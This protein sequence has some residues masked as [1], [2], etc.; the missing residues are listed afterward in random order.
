MSKVIDITD[1]LSFEENPKILIKN[2]EVSVNSDATT[3][4]QI[5]Q[6]VGEGKNI[7]P[8]DIVSL[9]DLLF[10][11]DDQKKIKKLNLNIKDFQTV[12]QAAISIITGSNDDEVGEKEQ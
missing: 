8:K 5:M 11:E 12:V 4:L 6:I 3:M 10:S 1:K 9:Y 2:V 7:T